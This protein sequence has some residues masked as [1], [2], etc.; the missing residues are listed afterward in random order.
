MRALCG[1]DGPPC[2]GS[3]ARPR[4]HRENLPLSTRMRDTRD[5]DD[6][7][8][9]RDP[10]EGGERHLC[11]P[12]DIANATRGHREHRRRLRGTASTPAPVSP[13]DRPRH[14]HGDSLD[15]GKPQPL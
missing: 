5:T 12:V 13:L 7:W 15:S 3:T 6:P 1:C 2:T 10:E 9:T 4:I 11:A 8:D 14:Q